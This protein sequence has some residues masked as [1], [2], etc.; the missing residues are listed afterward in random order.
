MSVL[1]LAVEVFM[2]HSNASPTSGVTFLKIAAVSKTRALW[3][4]GSLEN[5]GSS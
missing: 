3:G 2:K 1:S 5:G 4:T